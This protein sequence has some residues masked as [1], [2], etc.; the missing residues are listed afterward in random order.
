MELIYSIYAIY[1][2]ATGTAE[3]DLAFRSHLMTPNY[4][5]YRVIGY[6]IGVLCQFYITSSRFMTYAQTSPG[7]LYY[8]VFGEHCINY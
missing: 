3:H 2:H 8:V 4:S 5:Y 6:P 1:T 7:N